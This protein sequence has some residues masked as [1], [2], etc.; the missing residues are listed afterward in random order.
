V[1]EFSTKS[2]NDGGL[3]GDMCVVTIEYSR[4]CDAPTVLMAKFRPPDIK[5]RITTALSDVCQHEFDFY[6]NIQPHMPIRIPKM[7]FGEFH[8]PSASFIML[9]EL[10]KAEFGRIQ[11]PL[12]TLKQELVVKAMA[13]IHVAFWGAKRGPG[14][15]D[16]SWMPALNNPDLMGII[17]TVAKQH[18][19]TLYKKELASTA[20]KMP[21]EMKVC[22]AD[23]F[24]PKSM[25]TLI[26]YSGSDN[27]KWR[28]VYHGDTRTDN[29]FFNEEGADT[30]IGVLDWQLLGRG[31]CAIDLSW[32]FCTSIDADASNA[33]LIELYFNELVTGLGVAA[34]AAL[35]LEEF[36]QE[37]ALAHFRSALLAVLS[38]GNDMSDPNT[39]DTMNII[40]RRSIQSMN[41]HGSVQVYDLFKKGE[42]ISQG[43]PTPLSTENQPAV[44]TSLIKVSPSKK[45]FPGN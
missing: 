5:T 38:Q 2:A 14:N 29:W 23:Y 44:M 35:T 31:T 45:V 8:R 34:S 18:H 26:S 15:T 43:G 41:A 13:K 22:L 10:I 27:H 17:T 39:V 42:L 30:E 33:Y 25:K 28:S 21:A 40:L 32:F 1:A 16:I 19:G 6:S 7:I 11:N 12:S 4:P 24:K 3:L 20:N 36:K 37:L 9:F